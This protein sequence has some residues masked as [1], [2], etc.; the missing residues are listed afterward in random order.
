M[1]SEEKGDN[2]YG[3]GHMKWRSNFE[4]IMY[5]WFKEEGHSTAQVPITSIRSEEVNRMDKEE[6]PRKRKRKEK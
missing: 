5:S 4:F 3:Y 6:S 1:Y 2:F